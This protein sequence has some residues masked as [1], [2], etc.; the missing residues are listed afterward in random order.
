M[1][2]PA[3][4]GPP[5]MNPSVNPGVIRPRVT[6]QVPKAPMSPQSPSHAGPI[7]GG[8]ERRRSQRVLLRVRAVVHMLWQGVSSSFEVSTVNVNVHGALVVMKQGL[9]VGTRMILEHAGTKE[10]IAC[11]VVRPARETPD[12]FHTALE[13][14]LPAPGFWK[15][16]FPPVNWRPEDS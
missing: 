3:K 8:E 5:K 15:I 10:R 11:R 2:N 16:A 9:P 14:D 6:A 4:A 12:G 13:F 7:A 1:M